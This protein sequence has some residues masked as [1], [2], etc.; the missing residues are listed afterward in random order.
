[1][2]KTVNFVLAAVAFCFILLQRPYAQESDVTEFKILFGSCN[3]VELQNP[4][5]EQMAQNQ[6]DVFIWGG[7]AIYADTRNMRKMKKMY[8]AQKKIPDYKAFA[9][10]ILV[11]G[12]WDD[13]DYGL[14]DAGAEYDQKQKSQKLFLDFIEI[15]KNAE[16]RKTEGVYTSRDFEV[17]GK[18][19]KIIILDTRYFRS[20]LK[21]SANPEKRYDP[22]TDSSKTML[23]KTQWDWLARELQ[24]KT[25]F[26]VIMSSIQFLSHEHGFEAWG[27][28]PYEVARFEGLIKNSNANGVILLSGDR[29]IAE[30]SKKE[31]P[32]LQ[33]PLI[34]FTSSGL[35]HTYTAFDGEP[36]EYRVGEVVTRK[37]YGLVSINLNTN[38]V[39]F[40][41]MGENN[42]VLQ[43]IEQ[44]Y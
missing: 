5:W 22:T 24:D 41:I 27:N 8:V 10:S 13:H 7:D 38:A 25:D 39:N 2:K 19:I 37:N 20:N 36:N 42:E 9:E 32:G 14:N 4:F 44:D 23:G 6:A 35:T 12:T 43:E 34:D 18:K 1:M 33:Y 11:M 15:P 40:K 26:T 3:R 31:I 29:H 28:F 16:T 30:F 17:S 21:R